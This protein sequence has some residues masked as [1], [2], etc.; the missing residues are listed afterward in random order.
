FNYSKEHAETVYRNILGYARS[1]RKMLVIKLHPFSYFEDEILKEDDVVYVK[2]E[3][4][5]KD[6]ILGA[7]AV[8]SFPSTLTIPA[9]YYKPVLLLKFANNDLLELINS[10]GLL[11]VIDIF[12]LKHNSPDP[13]WREEI[14]DLLIKIC[15]YK[16]DG[17]SL[18]R[19]KTAFTDL[20]KG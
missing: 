13:V 18:Q 9:I 19:L 7:D 2:D 20:C 4:D 12:E 8:L 15:L 11:P 1:R 16:T 17:Q 14:R 5:H 6:L 10:N 3:Y